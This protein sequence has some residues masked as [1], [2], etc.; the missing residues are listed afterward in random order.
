M[1]VVLVVGLATG[2][3]HKSG[4]VNAVD[5]DLAFMN[6]MNADSTYESARQSYFYGV[7]TTCQQDCQNSL[8]PHCAQ[9]CQINRYTTL[10]QAQINMFSLALDTCT[11]FTVDQCAQARAMVDDCTAQFFSQTYSDMEEMSA[12]ADRLGACRLASKIDSCQ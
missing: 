3:L 4:R 1:A 7:P 6:Y 11:P 5:C 2:D 12:A 8:D 9:D 10:G